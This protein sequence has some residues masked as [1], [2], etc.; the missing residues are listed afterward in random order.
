MAARIGGHDL[1]L[2]RKVDQIVFETRVALAN[3]FNELADADGEPPLEK[4]QRQVGWHPDLIASTLTRQAHR[5]CLP[6][7]G[8][9]GSEV[10]AVSSL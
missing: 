9:G 2:R 8:L 7:V 10:G 5:R 4:C 3:A 6:F 1:Q